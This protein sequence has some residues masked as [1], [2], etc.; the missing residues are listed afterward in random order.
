MLQHQAVL[1]KKLK[2]TTRSK[3]LTSTKTQFLVLMGDFNAKVGHK[4]D[5]AEISI[6]NHSFRRET[7]G[8]L[9]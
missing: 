1:K 5:E 8:E 4:E 9:S 3:A 7:R 2:C 6:G